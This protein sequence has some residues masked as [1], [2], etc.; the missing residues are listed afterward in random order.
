MRTTRFII[1]A[2]VVLMAACQSSADRDATSGTGQTNDPAPSEQTSTPHDD[3]AVTLTLQEVVPEDAEGVVLMMT[4]HASGEFTVDGTVTGEFFVDVDD[5]SDDR[6]AFRY[7][8]L[9]DAG[10]VVFERT[11]SGP[12]LVRAYLNQ[13]GTMGDVDLLSDYPIL[14]TFTLMVPV[15]SGADTVRFQSRDDDGVYSEVGQYDLGSRHQDDV[16]PS[17][18]VIGH[19]TIWS[20][21][22]PANALD[23]VLVG[24]GYTRE[25]MSTWID[26]A[27]DMAQELLA[28]APFAQHTGR[29]NIHRV[30]AVSN[31]SG[32]SYDCID[33]CR[34]RDTAFGTIF[35]VELINQTM[36]THYSSRGIFQLKQWEVARAVSVVPYDA[37]LVVANTE[38]SGG[39]GVHYATATNDDADWTRTGV[40]ELAH[41]LG[42]LGDEYQEDACLVDASLGL[43]ANISDNPE[44][45]PWSQWIEAGTPLPTPTTSEHRHS[46]GA[47][48][49]AYNCPDLVRPARQCKMRWTGWDFC[50]VCS[51]ILTLQIYQHADFVDAIHIEATETGW[52]LQVETEWPQVA[53]T[54][55][56][57]G[58][59]TGSGSAA[60]IYAIPGDG[61]EVTVEVQL[62]ADNV[63]ATDGRLTETFQYRVTPPQ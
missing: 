19:Q 61:T 20:G 29:I 11:T 14:G 34:L 41:I 63:R 18:A 16:G 35:A 42:P 47:F 45:P 36:G 25:Q 9:D 57:D 31:E 15:I 23:I 27:T 50:P 43:P 4:Q 17:E 39:M 7:Q 26:D 54:V 12:A 55:I 38:R 48:Q 1:A 58:V 3:D 56:S 24:D 10:A 8:L 30:D 6:E 52:D 51:E 60:S 53:V 40:H 37:V 33:A 49:G 22:D 62:L 59:A 32:V 5:T 44:D 46:V 28:T 2:T 21:A 13:Y